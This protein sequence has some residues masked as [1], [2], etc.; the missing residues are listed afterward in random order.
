MWPGSEVCTTQWLLIFALLF[1]TG[2]GKIQ[3]WT[4][5]NSRDQTSS[6]IGEP[7]A[8]IWLNWRNSLDHLKWGL[9]TCNS[10]NPELVVWLSTTRWF[11]ESLNSTDLQPLW[12][13]KTFCTISIKLI[14]SATP[15]KYL[16]IKIKALKLLYNCKSFFNLI[17]TVF[18]NVWNL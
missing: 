17:K 11:S 13:K 7:S 15:L 2:F 1:L 8:G 18:V 4:S 3:F 10:L 16:N 6:Y 5:Y 9:I 12:L 14:S